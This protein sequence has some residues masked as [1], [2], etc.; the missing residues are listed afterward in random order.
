MTVLA[1]CKHELMVDKPLGRAVEQRGRR[2]DV[3]GR[4]LDERLVALLWVLL[5]GIAEEAGTDS[6]SDAVEVLARGQDVMLVPES[7]EMNMGR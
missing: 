7:A 6:A 1:R 4:A 2:V 5:R 3:D